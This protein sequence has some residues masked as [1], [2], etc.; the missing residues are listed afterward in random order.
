MELHY[1]PVYGKASV[2]YDIYFRKV[3][4]TGAGDVETRFNPTGWNL[5]FTGGV[6]F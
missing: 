1:G 3:T 4:Y 5:I 6:N 2:G